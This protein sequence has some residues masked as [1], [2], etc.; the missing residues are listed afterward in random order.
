MTDA[1]EVEAL[2]V[3]AGVAG[4]GAAHGLRRRGIRALV[5]DPAPAPGGAMRSE[6]IGPWL[7]EHG[8][9]TIAV[10]P[11]LLELLRE[12]G[13]E[14]LLVPAAPANR[15]RFLVQ[16]GRLEPLPTGLGS[17]VRTPLLSARGKL[18]ILAEPFVRRGD[19]T[20]ESVAAFAA[21]RLG[22]EAAE[23]LVGAFLTGIYAGD[24]RRLGAEAVFPSLVAYEREHGSLVRGGLAASRA[25]KRAKKEGGPQGLRGIHSAR[26]GL[27]SLAAALAEHLD[28]ELRL[29][30]RVVSLT[31]ERQNGGRSGGGGEGGR[32]DES[33]GACWRVEL[34]SRD[35]AETLRTR[36]VVL[37]TPAP[38]AA[39]LLRSLESEAAEILASLE[40]APLAVAH[41]G[42]DRGATREPVRGFGLLVPRAEGLRLLGC[43]FPGELFPDRAPPDRSLLTCMIGGTRWPEAVDV[44]DD[45]LL[46]GLLRELDA[47]LGLRGEPEVLRIVRWRR[48]V[49]Q[50]GPDHPRRIA[51]L[52]AGVARHPGLSLAGAYL[53]GVA[54]PDAL[55]SG[56]NK[57]GRS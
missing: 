47:I 38:E 14:D 50:P 21:R 4:L 57:G 33:G 52:R 42:V 37:A 5:V 53:D 44:P 29:E 41:L 7:V 11:P 6:R 18:R 26:E 34:E 27:G 16:G 17:A 10:R 9:N 1:P 8:P 49:C 19:P 35:G 36:R 30:T 54:V 2:V 15:L 24:E 32:S 46:E 22:P 56:L 20:G 25:A 40:Y 55:A 39:E 43:L 12:L 28:G 13:A 23:R 45:R 48:A 51:A 3:G 31:P